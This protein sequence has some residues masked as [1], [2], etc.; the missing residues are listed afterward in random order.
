VD[1]ILHLSI[2]V[3]DLEAARDFYVDTLG[4]RLG[5]SGID[6]VDI[7]FYGL[8]LTLQPRPDEVLPDDQQGTRHFGVTLDRAEL[9]ALMTRLQALPV[10]W[11]SPLSTDTTGAVRGKTSAKLA[12]P[13]GNVIEFKS[14]DDPRAAL[15]TP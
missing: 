10:R 5:A 15:G 9:D 12:D 4:C 11:V 6:G 2:P 7:W 1:P 3:K 14:Y 13:S 8:Q